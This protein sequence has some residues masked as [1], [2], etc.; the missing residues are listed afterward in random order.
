MTP[1]GI[2]QPHKDHYVVV[3]CRTTINKES[4]REKERRVT[5]VSSE[6]QLNEEKYMN[7]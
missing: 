2:T 4:Q 5:L 6:I 3:S 7:K 1:L